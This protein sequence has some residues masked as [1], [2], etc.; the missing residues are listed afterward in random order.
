[1]FY[2]FLRICGCIDIEKTYEPTFANYKINDIEENII[3]DKNLSEDEI[4]FKSKIKNDN[5]E[6]Y[7]NNLKEKLYKITNDKDIPYFSFEGKRYFARPS[8][9]YDGDTFSII[10]E[11]GNKNIIKYRC[12]CLG[13]DSAEMKPSLS[14]P[15]RDKEKEL[16]LAAKKRFTELL[17]AH[18]SGLIL[19]ECHGF[20]KYGRI[21]VTIYNNVDEMSVNE[22][23]IIEG[24][25]K[26]YDGGKKDVNW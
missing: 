9:I 6:A 18:N 15:N 14:N 11:D 23:M 22:L 20:D 3:Y 13:Y 10:F 19:V 26:P 7:L 25:G 21:L 16:A 17:M 24:H 12:R 8:N 5:K 2:R 4:I 1:M